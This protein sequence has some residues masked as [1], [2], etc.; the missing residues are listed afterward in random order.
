MERHLKQNLLNK[1]AVKIEIEFKQANKF[2][3]TGT[4]DYCK[5]T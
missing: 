2:N 4:V 1:I 5:P 3:K